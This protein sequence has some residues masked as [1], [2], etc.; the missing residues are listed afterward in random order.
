MPSAPPNSRWSRRSPRPR[1]PAPAAPPRPSVGGQGAH[2]GD[3]QGEHDRPGHQHASP[4]VPST[5]VSSPKPT[6]ARASPAAITSPGRARRAS[7]GASI[8][9]SDQPGRADGSSPQAGLQRRQPEDKLEVL[10]DEHEGAE[11]DEE[12]Q[13]EGGQEALKARLANSDRSSS[14]S[15]RRRCR[16][17]N[18]SPTAEPGQDRQRRLP[19]EAVLG[20][21]L[22][23][24]DDR[25]HRDQR[26]G[27]AEQV[28]AAGVRVAVLGQQ[29]R[30]PRTSRAPSPGPRAG[31]PSPTRTTPA[32]PRPA[33][34]RSRRR[35]RSWSPTRRSPPCAGPGR[36]TCCGSATGSTAPGSP[37]PRPAGRGRDQHLGAG[38]ER[39]QHRGDPEG[40]G[41]DQQQLRRPIRSPRVP[42]VISDP[43]TRNP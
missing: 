18:A 5:R 33:A 11:G 37:R 14:G 12:A 35:P 9:P 25:Q 21:L 13:G 19:A 4:E 38:G 42:M 24:V 6:A 17:T 7:G 27:R 10:G 2:R 30:G 29:S 20:E 40:G 31:T 28:Q 23:P 39:G 3:A 15:A 16:R 22:E 43:A 41:A 32:A 34:G 26:H 1:R 8:D 36:R